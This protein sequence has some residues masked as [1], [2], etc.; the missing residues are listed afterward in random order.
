MSRRLFLCG[1]GKQTQ[2][3]ARSVY[4]AL[5]RAVAS[6]ADRVGSAVYPELRCYIGERKKSM[7]K[8]AT[9]TST[10]WPDLRVHAAMRGRRSCTRMQVSVPRLLPTGLYLIMTVLRILR[11]LGDVTMALAAPF[12]AARP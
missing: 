5:P 4:L 12:G 9:T 8:P 2:R 11:R 10:S 3:R 6:P 7:T 1:G